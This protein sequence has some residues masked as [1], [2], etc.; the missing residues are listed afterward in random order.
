M[1]ATV[2]VMNCGSSS[3]KFQ[4]FAMNAN[5]EGKPHLKGMVE[6]IGLHESKLT[7]HDLQTDQRIAIEIESADHQQ[8]LAL[9]LKQISRTAINAVGH[10]V[11]HGGP[12]FDRAIILD[13]SSIAQIEQCIPLAPL[14]TPH[15]LTGIR[16]CMQLLPDIPHVA[17]FDTAFHHN[18]PEVSYLFALPYD[19]L[20]KHNIRKYGFH[21]ASHKYVSQRAAKILAKK[22]GELKLVTCHLGNGSTVTAVDAGIAV[23]TSAT[24]GTMCGLPMGTRS[25]DF[26]PSLILHLMSLG[27][28]QTDI[29]QMI[30]TQSGLLGISGVSS[31]MRELRQAAQ[32]G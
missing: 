19:L 25:G 18:K 6:K 12:F 28:S 13:D 8:A 15:V 23:D 14:H 26:D 24:F 27:Y 29:Y 2:L 4:I 16:T 30:Y 1:K 31:D 11:I 5:N 22:P 20:S 17:S 9:I 10:R 7:I 21:G 3:I 32:Q